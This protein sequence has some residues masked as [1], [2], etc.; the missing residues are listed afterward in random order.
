MHSDF[1]NA[2]YESH[3]EQSKQQSDVCNDDLWL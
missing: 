2:M 3:E 1:P